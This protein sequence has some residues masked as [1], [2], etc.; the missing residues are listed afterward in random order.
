M[1]RKYEKISVIDI[2]EFK[3]WEPI[4]AATVADYWN[5]NI[6][7]AAH[8]YYESEREYLT[9]EYSTKAKEKGNVYQSKACQFGLLLGFACDETNGRIGE[10][11]RAIERAI[12]A[13]KAYRLPW[14]YCLHTPDGREINI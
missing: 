14:E 7:K 9:E 1:R 13:G 8:F 3:S 2:E 6:A 11:V 5:E 12:E 4:G 10:A